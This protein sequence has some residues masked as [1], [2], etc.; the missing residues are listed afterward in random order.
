[1]DGLSKGPGLSAGSGGALVGLID[2]KIERVL[3]L[4]RRHLLMDVSFISEFSGGRQI[5]QGVSGQ[6]DSFGIVLGDGPELGTT[7]CQ[8]MIDGTLPN[9]VPDS[10]ADPRVSG[11]AATVERRIG[12]Y[13][14]VPLRLSDGSLYGTFC[15]MS[16]GA[17]SLD[18]R[19]AGFMSMLAEVLVEVLDAH[20]SAARERSVIEEILATGS[21][22]SVFQPIVSLQDGR[23]V[24]FEALSRFF[25]GAGTPEKVF[26]SAHAAGL[27][28]ELETLAL[29][30]AMGSLQQLPADAYL[31]MNLSPVTALVLPDQL[32]GEA[33]L[34]GNRMVLE[35][36]ETAAV[37]GY[38]EL[39]GRLESLR[40]QGVRVAIDDAGAGFASL[41]HIVELRPD[42]VKVDQSLIQGMASDR[43]RL[44][45]VRA[46][47]A[48]AEDLGA[49]TVAEGVET[50]ADLDAARELGMTCAQ[51]FL[52]GRPGTR[53]T[54]LAYPLKT[55]TR[56]P[57]GRRLPVNAGRKH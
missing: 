46:F 17:E 57:G 26:T 42:I 8:Q 37:T 41:H 22:H 56:S 53:F 5:Y 21:V 10:R 45:A 48:L 51:G 35:I 34:D 43:S 2:A 16:H 12:S 29:G 27:G 18:T 47:V 11:L 15:C 36:T 44:S 13:V 3:E 28:I 39:R 20:Q 49:A 54:D 30:Q 14:G 52:L 19:D 50:P 38:N 7:Y 25:H 31:A 24:G 9:V 55:S 4:A 32:L 1:M 40:E 33:G 23:I 6:A